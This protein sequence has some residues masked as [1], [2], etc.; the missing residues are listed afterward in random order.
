MRL[1]VSAPCFA[2][3]AYAQYP[4]LDVTVDGRL[5]EPYQ[6]AGRFI[7]LRLEGGEHRIVL[8]PR[9]SPLRRALLALNLVL[10]VAAGA[11]LIRTRHRDPRAD[12]PSLGVSGR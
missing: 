8:D 10:A 12:E 7:A 5:V 4:Y 9:L 2:R 3:L 1:H 11:V 6:T